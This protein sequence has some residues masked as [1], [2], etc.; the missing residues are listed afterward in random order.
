MW[1]LEEHP[2][3]KGVDAQ[4]EKHMSAHAPKLPEGNFHPHPQWLELPTIIQYMK[5]QINSKILL[6][7]I[8]NHKMYFFSS[9]MHQL[10]IYGEHT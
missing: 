2:L 3:L 8:F 7:W 9:C 4:T 10:G 1:H 5:H 6:N